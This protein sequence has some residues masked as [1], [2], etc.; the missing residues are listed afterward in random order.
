MPAAGVTWNEAARFA[1]W[2]NTSEGFPPAYKF[3]TQPR[4]A[5]Y[6]VNENIL[7]WETGDPGFDATNPFRNNLAR[8]VLPSVDEWFKAAYYDP[9][10]ND[11]AGGY[12]KYPTGSDSADSS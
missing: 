12:W 5:G 3:A 2:L 4:D 7:L 11:G 8:Y 1:N 10:A 6:R 9:N